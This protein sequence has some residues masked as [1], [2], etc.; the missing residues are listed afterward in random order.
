MSLSTIFVI[1]LIVIFLISSN[2][3]FQY[4]EHKKHSYYVDY[5]KFQ[6]TELVINIYIVSS[7]FVILFIMF[8]FRDT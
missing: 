8:Y 7:T 6:K 1:A 5:F 2:N 3:I 4:Y